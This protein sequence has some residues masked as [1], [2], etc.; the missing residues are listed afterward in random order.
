MGDTTL[1][2]VLKLRRDSED[3]Y[4]KVKDSFIPASGEVCL[5]DTQEY[6]LRSKIGDGVTSYGELDY[7]DNNNNVVLI[8]YFFNEKFYTDSTYTVELEKR[9]KHLYIDKNSRS[10]VYV[11]TG[12][13][14]E[15]L[16]T[17]ATETVA[18][19]MKLYQAHGQNINGTMSQK[20]IT[21]GVNS[22]KLELDESDSECL[23]LDLPWD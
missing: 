10:S 7:V 6:G 20:T 17:E 1:S 3:N 13:K 14:F 5:V 22:I 11:W 18:G 16:S 8:G 19:I 23:I 21:D 12:E 15:P 4:N 2:V 9:E